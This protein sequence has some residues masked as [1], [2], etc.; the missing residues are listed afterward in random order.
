[1]IQPSRTCQR[2][3]EYSRPELQQPEFV[4]PDG[5][6][7]ERTAIDRL[8]DAGNHE[9]AIFVGD[10]AISDNKRKQPDANTSNLDD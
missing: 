4:D 2:L 9:F 6:F 7:D 10:F 1:M 3:R 5:G 8:S